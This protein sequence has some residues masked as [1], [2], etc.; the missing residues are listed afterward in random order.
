V[1]VVS[2]GGVEKS[3]ALVVDHRVDG[4]LKSAVRAPPDVLVSPGK[5]FLGEDLLV[6]LVQHGNVPDKNVTNV[7]VAG[8]RRSQVDM[9]ELELKRMSVAVARKAGLEVVE[10]ILVETSLA[11]E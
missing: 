7:E 10:A 1:N 8:H 3:L 4:Y 11:D 2:D 5:K 9:V 6:V